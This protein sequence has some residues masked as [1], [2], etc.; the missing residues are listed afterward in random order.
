MPND[1]LLELTAADVLRLTPTMRA[2]VGAV[3][4]LRVASRR[5]GR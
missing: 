3:L 4:R 2:L 1:D 5:G